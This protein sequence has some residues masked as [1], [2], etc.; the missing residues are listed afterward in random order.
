MDSFSNITIQS[1]E[2]FDHM[3]RLSRLLAISLTMVL[4][5]TGCLKQAG[6]SIKESDIKLNSLEQVYH[7]DRKT[8]EQKKVDQSMELEL[9]IQEGGVSGVIKMEQSTTTTMTGKFNGTIEVPQEVKDQAR[10]ISL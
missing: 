3:L 1:E 6:V 4:L 9:P 5:F 8:F 10:E 7:I 2:R